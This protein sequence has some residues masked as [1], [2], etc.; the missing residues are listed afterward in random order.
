MLPGPVVAECE[1][2]TQFRLMKFKWKSAAAAFFSFFLFGMY[3]K[4]DAQ[5]SVVR[6]QK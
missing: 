1:G 3:K 2:A 5:D 4:F 6:K